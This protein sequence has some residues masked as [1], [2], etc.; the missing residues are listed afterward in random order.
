MVARGPDER[1][2]LE[3]ITRATDSY[4]AALTAL[5]KLSA[6]TED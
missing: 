5:V 3:N 1:V 6:E 2:S 4:E